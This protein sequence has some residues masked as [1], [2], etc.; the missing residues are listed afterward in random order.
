MK[1]MITGPLLGLIFLFSACGVTYQH[2]SKPPSER[3]KDQHACEEQVRD[4]M[5][6]SHGFDDSYDE[7]RVIRSCMKRKG[8]QYK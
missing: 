7:W 2:P 5:H 3:I 4:R 8:W 1:W 6:A